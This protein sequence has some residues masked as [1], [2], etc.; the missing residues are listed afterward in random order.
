MIKGAFIGYSSLDREFAHRLARDLTRCGIP[1]WFDETELEPCD[2]IIGDIED[3]IDA[4][5]DEPFLRTDAVGA[6]VRPF[7]D[8]RDLLLWHRLPSVPL[9]HSLTGALRDQ[10]LEEGLLGV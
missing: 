8:L 10:P 7:D 5:I 2:S 4:R 6:D 1:V 3:A 9:Y